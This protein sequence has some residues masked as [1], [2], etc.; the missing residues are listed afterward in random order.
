MEINYDKLIPCK[1]FLY[2]LPK[3]EGVNK[4]LFTV[5]FL[6]EED[7][8]YEVVF[9]KPTEQS[10]YVSGWYLEKKQK[11]TEI[12]ETGGDLSIGITDSVATGER[13]G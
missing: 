13:I 8:K 5:F 6:D 1:G 7:N 4:D 9:A 12:V 3:Q 2:Q 10:G 11:T